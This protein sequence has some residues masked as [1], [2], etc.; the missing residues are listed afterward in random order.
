MNRINDLFQHKNK[1][2]LS[3]YFT[4]GHPQLND[5]VEIIN[6]LVNSGVDMIEIGMPFSDPLADGTVIQQS[7]QQ[8][9]ING[10][11]IKNLFNQ[12]QN[13]RQ[14]INIPLILMGYL[15]PVM[16]YGFE[17]F[18]KDAAAIGIDGFIL[19]DLPLKEYLN[20]Y[21][22]IAD[23]Y[24][25]CNIM[26]ITPQ[27]NDERIK[28]IDNASNGFIYMVSSA[29]TTGMKTGIANEQENYF[30]HI[31]SLQLKNPTIIGFG[32]SNKATFDIACKYA[33]GAIIGSAF[34]NTLNKD[35]VNGIG[36]FIQ[37][38]K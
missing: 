24:N 4:A 9:L 28:E 5:T 15:N 22:N 25:L 2:I 32:I 7:S 13:I 23:K 3:I 14:N 18:C 37:Q 17:N 33:N 1:N 12:L 38:I 30:K 10:M 8:A 35:G 19:P 11:S 20:E 29:S 21:K 16:Q 34:V 27:T 36:N 31:A 26:L 6:K